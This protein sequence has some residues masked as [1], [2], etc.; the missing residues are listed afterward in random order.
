MSELSSIPLHQ[1]LEKA[2]WYEVWIDESA[3][4]VLLLLCISD[5]DYLIADPALGT[6]RDRL[7]SLE[8]ARNWLWE[9]EY[10]LVTGRTKAEA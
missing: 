4:Y 8:S 5:S 2:V 7:S 10:T 9:D 3:P 1:V 6:I